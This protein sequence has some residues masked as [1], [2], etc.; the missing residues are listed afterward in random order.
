MRIKMHLGFEIA[1]R[2]RFRGYS[3]EFGGALLSLSSNN[4]LPVLEP[5]A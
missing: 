2:G 4:Q 5:L 3:A 1:A